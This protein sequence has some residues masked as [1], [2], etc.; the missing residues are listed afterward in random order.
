MKRIFSYT[1]PLLLIGAFYLGKH[2]YFQP[3]VNDGEAAPDF[4]AT[5]L[6]GESFKLSDLRGQYVLLDFWGSWCGPCRAEN[7]GLVALQQK[8]T[9]SQFRTARAFQIVSVAV[10][11]SGQAER[12]KRAINRDGL[13]WPYQILDESTSLRFFNAP[14][15]NQFGVKELPSKF[16]LGPDGNI[17]L[18][19]P[20]LEALDHYLSDQTQ[21]AL[22]L[23]M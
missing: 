9:G 20:S 13:F 10:E 7:P 8:Y 2:F 18:V 5:L 11:K 15:A 19:N 17:L 21:T 4:A 14:I 1:W 3:K 6:N 23:L 22:G 16:L 12:W